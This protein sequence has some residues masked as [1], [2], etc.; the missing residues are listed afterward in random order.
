M[1]THSK[2]TTR[3]RTSS[4]DLHKNWHTGGTTRD[5]IEVVEASCGTF[6]VKKQGVIRLF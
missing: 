6:T 2:G 1:M 5:K 4:Y 3:I